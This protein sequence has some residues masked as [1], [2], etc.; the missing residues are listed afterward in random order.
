MKKTARDRDPRT[1]GDERE[2]Q[3]SGETRIRDELLRIELSLC[4]CFSPTGELATSTAIVDLQRD[5][6]DI[7][8]GCTNEC[9]DNH[10]NDGSNDSASKCRR[11]QFHTSAQHFA[12]Y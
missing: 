9:T 8:N 12:H 5:G 6:D 7:A 2:M 1:R 3:E 10:L 11:S 4:L